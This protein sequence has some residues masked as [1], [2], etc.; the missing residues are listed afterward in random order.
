MPINLENIE[1]E[2]ERLLESIHAQGV[3]DR[4][5]EIPTSH[6]PETPEQYLSMDLRILYQEL[7]DLTLRCALRLNDLEEEE[8]TGRPSFWLAWRHLLQDSYASG[9]QEQPFGQARNWLDAAPFSLRPYVD[10]AV[11]ELKFQLAIEGHIH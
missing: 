2:L 4:R 6:L 10:A 1:S 3:L 7:S 5:D 11:N 8:D 9:Y